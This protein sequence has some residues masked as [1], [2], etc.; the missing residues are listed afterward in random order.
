MVFQPLGAGVGL[1]MGIFKIFPLDGMPM[2]NMMSPR[3]QWKRGAH[4]QVKDAGTVIFGDGTCG[5]QNN[6]NQQTPP[7]VRFVN[8]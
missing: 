1:R 7:T 2:V 6:W 3:C 4:V 5:I 8:G